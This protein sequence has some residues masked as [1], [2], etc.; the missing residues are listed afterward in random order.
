MEQVN[1]NISVSAL[2][3][4]KGDVTHIINGIDGKRYLNKEYSDLVFEIDYPLETKVEVK[5]PKAKNIADIL[6]PIAYVYKNVIYADAEKENK[7]GVWGH[8]IG[9]LY[10]EGI[11]INENGKSE[12]F[13]G[14]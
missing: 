3:E 13:I 8:G 6:V 7:Y 5:I 9:D 12:L 1:L 14:S 10:F 4:I 2:A 11:V